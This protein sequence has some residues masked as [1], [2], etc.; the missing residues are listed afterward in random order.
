MYLTGVHFIGVHAT[1]TGGYF[2]GGHF[3]DG[4]LAGV[5]SVLLRRKAYQRASYKSDT[6]VSDPPSF[7]QS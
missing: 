2:T 3:I 6:L 4:H 7:R 1:A 5:Y